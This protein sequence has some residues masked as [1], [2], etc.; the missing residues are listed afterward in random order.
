M[1]L[2][3][4]VASHVCRMIAEY[5]ELLIPCPLSVR[6]WKLSTIHR[7]GGGKYAELQM[8]PPKH[9]QIDG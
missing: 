3:N 6:L 5:V 8:K 2:S 1:I 9:P 4:Q 7:Y